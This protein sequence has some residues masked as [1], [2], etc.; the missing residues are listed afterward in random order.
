MVP[1]NIKYNFRVAILVLDFHDMCQGV[2]Q[3]PNGLAAMAHKLLE[4]RGYNILTV[5]YNEFST[6]DK[7]L[8][9]VQ[10]LEGKLR[11]LANIKK[12]A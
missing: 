10:Y 4:Q 2:H 11:R 12:N 9:R 5:P 7:L 8:K 1:L 3:Q 6:S